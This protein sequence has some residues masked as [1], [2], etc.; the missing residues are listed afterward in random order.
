[1]NF[2]IDNG[3]IQMINVSTRNSNIL[4]LVLTN[5]PNA[6]FN[7]KVDAPIARSDHCCVNFSVALELCLS[8]M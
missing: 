4:D 1:M 2:A 6:L 8:H 3:F 5:E 7:I